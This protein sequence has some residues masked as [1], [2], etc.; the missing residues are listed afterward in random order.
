MEPRYRV[1][2]SLS[3]EDRA[4][5]REAAGGIPL[6]TWILRVVIYTAWNLQARPAEPGTQ[7]TK[8]KV[9]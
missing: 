7:S 6:A 8:K 5:L 4:L 3:P 2:L 1:N 9:Q